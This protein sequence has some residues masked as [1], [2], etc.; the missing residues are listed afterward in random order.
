VSTGVYSPYGPADKD[1]RTRDIA[2]QE[3]QRVLRS[4]DFVGT[5]VNQSIPQTKVAATPVVRTLPSKPTTGDE[6]Y[7]ETAYGVKV[8]NRY[9]GSEW[10]PVRGAVHW[11]GVGINF[12]TV[13]G[14][15]HDY[16]PTLTGT[17]TYGGFHPGE[18]RDGGFTQSRVRVSLYFTSAGATLFNYFFTMNH[19]FTAYVDWWGIG[20]GDAGWT[21]HRFYD[22]GW[23]TIPAGILNGSFFMAP[24]Y[25]FDAA[26]AGYSVNFQ[27]VSV[28]VR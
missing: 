21:G 10:L 18:L 7:Y 16:P 25:R 1:Q 23:F 2:N 15:N 4:G 6:V 20:S 9:D 13:D 22:S 12:G 14:A 24:G 26:G 28:E 27:F 3:I 5:L 17:V 19:V 11:Y 8:L